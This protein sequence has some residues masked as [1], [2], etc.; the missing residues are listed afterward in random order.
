MVFGLNEDNSTIVIVM[1]IICGTVALIAI[2]FF[3]YS[4]AVLKYDHI[5]YFILEPLIT[6]KFILPITN[7]ILNNV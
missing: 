4:S 6:N 2:L 3:V 1:L 5:H 7:S